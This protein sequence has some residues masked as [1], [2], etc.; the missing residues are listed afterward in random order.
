MQ[1]AIDLQQFCDV[2]SGRYA[3][4]AP[5][6]VDGVTYATN[7]RILVWVET[8]DADTAV[9]EGKR[10]LNVAAIV[11][12][13]WP[14]TG[15]EPWPE[16]NGESTMREC[17]CH[18][19]KVDQSECLTCNGTGELECDLGHEHEC[20]DCDG[21]GVVGS[22]RNCPEC[23]G[24]GKRMQRYANRV[25]GALIAAEYDEKI[26]ALPNARF[27]S[28]GKEQP[29]L[30]EFDGGRGM[31]MAIR[32]PKREGSVGNESGTAVRQGSVSHRATTVRR[33]AIQ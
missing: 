31:V 22:G 32:E 5:F 2:E 11:P 18:N 30:F 10:R 15:W 24:K 26:R 23:N 16:W 13:K 3:I 25:G 7:S 21:E 8:G 12:E 29:V 1:T 17:G 19:G 14:T 9:P 28:K 33:G 4:D 20:D 6:T 27:I